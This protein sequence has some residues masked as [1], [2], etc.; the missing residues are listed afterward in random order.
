[1]DEEE[2]REMARSNYYAQ[3]AGLG[4]GP[5]GLALEKDA[6]VV[7]GT[8]QPDVSGMYRCSVCNDLWGAAAKIV[9]M[10]YCPTCGA[11]MDGKEAKR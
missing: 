8:W 10:K 11:L 6:P 4:Y 5:D 9:P 3:L 1:M 7:H 2:K